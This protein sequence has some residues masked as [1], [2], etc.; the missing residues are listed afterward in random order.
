MAGRSKPAVFL[1]RDGTLI[2]EL[3]FLHQPRRVRLLH[4]VVRGLKQLK[5]AGFSVVVI[6]NQSGV[7]RGLLTMAQ[8]RAVNKRV[9]KLLAQRGIPLEGVYV[10]PHHPQSGC[11]CRK[12]K[13]GLVRRAARQLGLRLKGCYSLGDRASDVALA[14]QVGGKGILVLTGY[15]RRV[16]RRLQGVRPD[17]VAKNFQEA[18]RWILRQS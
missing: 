3:G 1:D 5:K 8:V 18:V 2:E 16:R 4:G 11:A 10:C 6:S 7:G 17:A 15:G 13:S 9:Q 12:P 14:Q